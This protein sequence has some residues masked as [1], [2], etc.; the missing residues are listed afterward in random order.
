MTRKQFWRVAIATTSAI[1]LSAKAAFAMPA[2]IGVLGSVFTSISAGAS[3]SAVVSGLFVAALNYGI[4]TLLGKMLAPNQKEKGI[5][6]KL[7]SGGDNPLSFIMGKYATAGKLVYVNQTGNDLNNMLVLVVSL[8]ELPVYALDS[9]IYINGEDEEIDFEADPLDSDGPPAGFHPVVSYDKRDDDDYGKQYCWVKFHDGTQTSADAYLLDKFGSDPDKPWSS[10]MVGRGC[11]YAIV[12]CRYSAKGVWSGIPEFKFVL[13]GIPLYDPRKDSSVGGSGSQRW[14]N[15]STWEYSDNPVVMKYN[16]IRGISYSGDWVWGGQNVDAYRLP[17]S[18]WFAAMN[19][20]DQT[21]DLQAGGTTTRYTAG[22]EIKVDQQPI[23]ILKELDKACTGYTTEYGGLWKTWA[24]PPGSSVLTIT[25]DD[26][27]IT[28]EQTDSLFRPSQ[29]IYNGARATYVSPAAG[30]VMKDAPPRTFSGLVDEDSDYQ[31]IAELQFPFVNNGNQ[32]QRLMRAAVQDSRRQITHVIT[33]PP[34]A[35]LLEPWDVINWNSTRNGYSNKK[36]Q[37][38]SIDDQPNVNQLVALRETNPNDYDWDTSYELPETVGPL[39]P[40][41]PAQLALDFTVSPAE[42][43][44]AGGNKDNPAMLVEWDWGAPDIDLRYIKW[45]VRKQGDTDIIAHGIFHN[46]RDDSRKIS[47]AA[48]RFNHIYE[49]HLYPEPMRRGRKS[50][51]TSW[52]TVNL[53]LAPT[54]PTSLEVDVG[55]KELRIRVNKCP[56]A[57]YKRTI[58][59]QAEGSN[60]FADAVEVDRF[61]GTSTS[62]KRLTNHVH[63]F[64]W[65]KFEDTSEALSARYPSGTG[66]EGVP[67]PFNETDLDDGSISTTKT[68]QRS[69]SYAGTTPSTDTNYLTID[70]DNVGGNSVR[71]SWEWILSAR[72]LVAAAGDASQVAL[73]ATLWKKHGAGAKR[74]MHTVHAKVSRHAGD[75][76]NKKDSSV[77]KNSKVFHDPKP[78]KGETTTYG[79]DVAYRGSGTGVHKA[80]MRK[81]E[82]SVIYNKR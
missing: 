15:H 44:S 80:A 43:R 45:E 62:I 11:A 28:E 55:N 4:Q 9:L 29:E 39:T 10:D 27:I 3:A 53:N 21:V 36:F 69:K 78:K 16:I 74:K 51:W 23:D 60:D 64:H 33:L 79:I 24:G 54:A 35:Y 71:I 7:E 26:I 19:H 2:A 72:Y 41:R 76:R 57:D 63:Y 75:K 77:H 20:C 67:A 37:V 52:K 14:N 50:G 65:A 30:W 34:E 82:L 13:K 6:Q 38:T 70:V 46:M 12:V 32:A 18:Y 59:Y 40:I 22:C 68:K 17:L 1:A 49:I 5:K 56:D 47:H 31:L 42:V 25:D 8:S 66:V 81:C 61:S 58:L 48:F 73:T